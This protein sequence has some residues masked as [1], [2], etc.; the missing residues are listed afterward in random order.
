MARN[1]AVASKS[2][3]R[4]RLEASPDISV[5]SAGAAQ[6][7]APTVSGGLVPAS[8]AARTICAHGQNGGAPSVSEQRPHSTKAPRAAACSAAAPAMTVLPIPASPPISTSWPRPA[9]A[10]SN[11]ARRTAS[12][13]SRPIR[14][15]VV[16]TCPLCPRRAPSDQG[17]SCSRMLKGASMSTRRTWENPASAAT[18]HSAAS[19]GIVPSP[20]LPWASALGVH[21]SADA[22]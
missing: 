14:P 17:R 15:P 20:A 4:A 3:N 2:R 11:E 19:P 6:P 8:A 12:T 7:S 22:A 9:A 16:L 5:S 10:W 1:R 13:W 18:S 21:T